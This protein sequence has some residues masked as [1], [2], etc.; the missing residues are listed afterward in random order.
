MSIVRGLVV[1]LQVV[2]PA[3]VF[4]AMILWARWLWRRTS[5][6]RWLVVAPVVVPILV[7]V[8]GLAF[9]VYRQIQA[10]VGRCMEPSERAT[11]LAQGISEALNCVTLGMAVATLAAAIM[12]GL[13]W[14]YRWSAKAK[15]ASG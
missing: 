7:T 2:L 12:L 5:A 8:P 15:R 6:P 4:V 11:R 10:F 14:R 13:T 3:G 9:G 1:A